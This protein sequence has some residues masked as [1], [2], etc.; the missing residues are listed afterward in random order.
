[1][2]DA[3]TTPVLP[4]GDYLMTITLANPDEVD[5]V[6]VTPVPEPSAFIVLGGSL[7]VLGLRFRRSRRR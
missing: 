6:V 4:A 7:V 5:A 2:T 1:M 3:A